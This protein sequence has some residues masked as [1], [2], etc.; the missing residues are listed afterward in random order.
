[1]GIE[2]FYEYPAGVALSRFLEGLRLGRLI[3]SK[4]SECNYKVVPLRAYCPRCYSPIKEYQTIE[5]VGWIIT[6]TR[7]FIN[8]EGKPANPP[9]TWVFVK[10]DGVE[11]GLLHILDPSINP[12][13]GLRVRPVYRE[14]RIGSILDI[15]YFTLI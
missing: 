4:C 9:V 14:Q 13:I 6:Y 7:S 15:K 10:F 3:A 5:D 2:S 1:M 8:I 11:G 12:R